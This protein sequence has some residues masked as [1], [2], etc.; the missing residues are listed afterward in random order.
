MQEGLRSRRTYQVDRDPAGFLWVYS[1]EGL[2]RFDGS[3][4]RPYPL[5]ETIMSRDH[6]QSATRLVHDAE[7][8]LYVSLR[9]GKVFCYETRMDRFRLVADLSLSLPESVMLNDIFPLSDAALLCATS[10]GLYR[11][12]AAP[13]DAPGAGTLTCC[14]L[15]GETLQEIKAASDGSLYIAARSG[16]F[17]ASADGSF[18]ERMAAIPGA[19][20]LHVQE[21]DGKLFLG[22]F[23]EGLWVYDGKRCERIGHLPPVPVRA[24]C[25]PSDG[26]LLVGLDGA[27]VFQVDLS[28]LQVTPAL[29]AEEGD[30]S[31]N[32]VSDLCA[33]PDGTLWVATTTGGLNRVQPEASTVRW[34]REEGWNNHVNVI[35]QDQDG[36]FWYGT[37]NGVSLHGKDG[38]IRHFLPGRVVLSLAQDPMGNV[39]VG[40]Y[41]MQPWRISKASGRAQP[42]PGAPLQY[43]YYI[44]PDG[45]TLWFGGLEGNF[46]RL[47]VRTGQ[48]QEYPFSCVGDIWPDGDRHLYLAGC[49]GLGR[50]DKETGEVTWIRDFG[51]FTLRYP[52]RALF[53]ASD[54]ALWMATDGDGLICH[55]PRSG[56]ALRYTKENGLL[57][58]SVISVH[59]DL[60]GRIWFT[61]EEGLFWLDPA[62]RTVIDAG[63]LLDLDGGIF[64]PNA[65]WLHADG[66]LSFGTSEGVL[67]F[68]AGKMDYFRPLK[69]RLLLTDLEI[70]Y[71]KAVPGGNVLSCSLEE[72]PSLTLGARSNSFSF[73]FS[74]LN[75]D[76]DFRVRYEYR[77]EGRD[78]H[79][80]ET[81]SAARA[82]YVEV[83]AGRYVFSLRAVDKYS[84]EQLALRMLPV[85]VLPPWYASGWAFV[86]YGLVLL[87]VAAWGLHTR[88][89]R[90]YE[91]KVRDKMRSFVS[92]AH[93][94]KTPV[95]LIKAPLG[96]LENRTDLPPDSREAVTLA[97]RNADRLM[98]MISQLL[99]LREAGDREAGQ[100]ELEMT[101]LAP[102]MS[103]CLEP[104][105]PVALQKGIDLSLDVSASMPKVPVDRKKLTSIMEN[106]L[107]NALK[108]TEKGAVDVAVRPEGRRYL[109][110]VSDTGIGI[111]A[112]EQKRLFSDSFRASNVGDASGTGIGLMITRELVR[113]LGGRISF[114]SGEGSGTRFRLSFPLH[115]RHFVPA[116]EAPEMPTTTV[117][118]LPEGGGDRVTVLVVDDEPDMLSYL[119]GLLR[120]DYDV[121]T[122]TQGNEALEMV[123]SRNPDV[124][125][126]DLVMPGLS[127]EE[128]CRLLKSSVET[129]HIPVILL[130]GVSARQSIVFGLEAVLKARL[131]SIIGERERLR[132]YLRATDGRAAASSD[133]PDWGSRL[134][135]EFMEKVLAVLE[136]EI[137]NPDFSI[138]DLCREVAMSR[139]AFFNKLKSLT[140]QG[141][142]DY[143]RTFRL[144]RAK[145]L[146][147][148]HRLSVQ[149]VS[150]RVGFSD[151][152]YFSSCFKKQFGESPSRI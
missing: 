143:I 47:D 106:L 150:D 85:R 90:I 64:N 123:R 84:G 19:A 125:I 121:L 8:R 34:I 133:V 140:G 152:K 27:G 69:I 96:D 31:D 25:S 109:I 98:E 91:Q 7:G 6:V 63:P 71:E 61:T 145:E 119:C 60:E 59:E 3:E 130:T 138:N 18:A 70:N 97:S 114:R 94:L 103:L 42:L 50:F 37:N 105:R 149:E 147:L 40:G 120:D 15:K 92:V 57:S 20:Y 23:S 16:V 26:I 78:P 107:S 126:T 139:T 73:L 32:T 46:C 43:I 5:D 58:N 144:N 118:A 100:L 113:S 75:F 115:Y 49:D 151:A 142:N 127:G 117:E 9:S 17:H 56:D 28:S 132:S 148:Q 129:S 48:W 112:Q 39:Y 137:A 45:D 29:S 146:L 4:F 111:P 108:Y 83:P 134:D 24:F 14:A 86:G 62:R 74:A 36:D 88:R 76:S 102:W 1:Q 12:E 22:T 95:S 30:L 93:D 41:G 128:L 87:A 13:G 104:F 44:Y 10:E 81:T 52:V 35:Y 72:T 67:S 33:D 116:E 68:D 11:F 79:W 77:L 135:R 141:P 124:V 110:E 80:R 101:D 2:V 99:D 89:R 66:T 136:R 55:D 54:G 21:V 51:P 53:R 82:E 65:A 38:S 122:A 131:G